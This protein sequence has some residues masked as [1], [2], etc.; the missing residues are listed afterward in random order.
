MAFM[1][2]APELLTNAKR[3]MPEAKSLLMFSIYYDRSE[4]EELPIGHGRVARYAWGR[5]Y[6]KVLKKRIDQLGKKFSQFSEQ[7]VQLRSFSDAIPILERAYAQRAGLGFIGKNTMLIQPGEGSFSFLAGMIT[8]AEVKMDLETP[9]LN[10]KNGCGVCR[11]CIDACPTL[12]IVEPHV[13]DARKCI[14]YL[15][16][17]K[18]GLLPRSERRDIGDWVFGCDVCQDV[19]PFNSKPLSKQMK[20]KISQLNAEAGVG[21]S[22]NLRELIRLRDDSGFLKKFAGTPLMRAKREG[23]LRNAIAVAVNS[24]AHNLID[25]ITDAFLGDESPVIRAMALWGSTMLQSES[26][27]IDSP[28]LLRLRDRAMSDSSSLVS[29]EAKTIFN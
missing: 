29:D 15:T 14:S 10:F 17:E 28:K 8:D 21:Q 2:K 11:R 3:L 13:V 20:S 18:R 16:I 27:N 23:L 9:P 5:D 22:L 1:K 7:S 12:A 4:R 26:E 24:H 25:D 19:C 6:H